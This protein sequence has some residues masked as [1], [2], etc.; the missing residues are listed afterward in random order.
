MIWP[1][2][3]KKIEVE[4]PAFLAAVE[5]EFGTS[6]GLVRASIPH[7]LMGGHIDLRA[8]ADGAGWVTADVHT[9]PDFPTSAEGHPY[10][11]FTFIDRP[12][13]EISALMTVLVRHFASNLLRDGD[14]VFVSEIASFQ[15]EYP[16]VQIKLFEVGRDGIAAYQVAYDEVTT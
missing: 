14:R 5:E 1:F 6:V 4:E 3:R 7:F 12:H 13:E 15:A 2:K 10:E 8:L 9:L 11:F 16:W